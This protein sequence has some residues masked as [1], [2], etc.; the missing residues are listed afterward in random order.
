MSGRPGVPQVVRGL[1]A[2]GMG[3]H[4]EMFDSEPLGGPVIIGLPPVR[5]HGAM[6]HPVEVTIQDQRTGEYI[7]MATRV[8]L[9]VDL[10]KNCVVAEVTELCGPEGKSLRAAP[11]K[12]LLDSEAYSA[13][14]LEWLAGPRTTEFEGD[15]YGSKV[16]R[17][18]V[19]GFTTS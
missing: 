3:E 12:S 10:A 5:G 8:Q 11:G 14:Y 16:F 2:Y 4:F 1:S 6:A 13:Q 7:L 18:V 17:Y 9:D 15:P 19:A